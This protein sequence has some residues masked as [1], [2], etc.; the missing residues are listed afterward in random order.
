MSSGTTSRPRLEFAAARDG[1]RFSQ[2]Q[3]VVGRDDRLHAAVLS[4]AQRPFWRAACRSGEVIARIGDQLRIGT[5][6]NAN[7]ER[8]RQSR[9]SA[10]SSSR[11]SLLI[12]PPD[13]L[14]AERASGSA[15]LLVVM[16]PLRLLAAATG[17]TH[18]FAGSSL[19]VLHRRCRRSWCRQH[20][21]QTL[22]GL[23]S[24][25]GR[26]TGSLQQTGRSVLLRQRSDRRWRRI[27]CTISKGRDAAAGWGVKCRILFFAV[28]N[29]CDDA[30]DDRQRTMQSVTTSS[31]SR[32]E[33][34]RAVYDSL[35][36]YSPAGKLRSISSSRRISSVKR[37]P[38][39]DLA[40]RSR[41][42][43]PASCG[44][45]GTHGTA[46]PQICS[47]SRSKPIFCSKFAG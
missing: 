15:D 39:G 21:L 42:G 8:M 23:S 5:H 7:S 28:E 16:K 13:R 17:I 10:Y 25:C 45:G 33:P 34:S 12:S 4:E 18:A 40:R 6:R 35:P 26:R 1:G 36:G 14:D 24:R 11:S 43:S 37:Q 44:T 47:R 29:E 31:T 3:P 38:P 9:R 2:H 20:G 19:G 41:K 30:A 32:N 46:A 27:R 22:G